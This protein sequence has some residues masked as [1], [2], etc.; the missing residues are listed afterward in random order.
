MERAI[1]A[2]KIREAGDNE[3]MISSKIDWSLID[4]VQINQTLFIVNFVL[5]RLKTL[6]YLED[7]IEVNQL[8]CR[9]LRFVSELS[10]SDLT[11]LFEPNIP[12][13]T[14]PKYVTFLLIS[15]LFNDLIEDFSDS[16]LD[17]YFSMILSVMKMSIQLIYTSLPD[18]LGQENCHKLTEFVLATRFLRTLNIIGQYA[19]KYFYSDNKDSVREEMLRNF[20]AFDSF[21]LIIPLFV[22]MTSEKKTDHASLF[23]QKFFTQISKC[24]YW[25]DSEC[26]TDIA[27]FEPNQYLLM[28][29]CNDFFEKSIQTE[30]KKYFHNEDSGDLTSNELSRYNH[31]TYLNKYYDYILKYGM[32]LLL[33]ED[34]HLSLSSYHLLSMMIA[35][36]KWNC[37]QTSTSQEDGN[38]VG[39]LSIT[40]DMLH[41]KDDIQT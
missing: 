34:A 8:K 4:P 2:V 1:N 15:E 6:Q 37:N 20:F 16:L 29:P 33:H 17:S 32:S 26:L 27:E 7:D 12:S 41:I 30:L 24:L 5:K 19:K 21:N 18:G 40:L 38:S 14:N 22:V 36:A 39:D 35:T 9:L 13:F 28:N 10:D 25:I 23:D 31:M 3:S 11:P